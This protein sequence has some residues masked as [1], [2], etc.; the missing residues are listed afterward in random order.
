[1]GSSRVLLV[2]NSKL[3]LLIGNCIFPHDWNGGNVL[4]HSITRVGDWK[5]IR[6]YETGREEHYKPRNDPAEQ[7]DLASDV[8][9]SDKRCELAAR[10]DVWMNLVDAQMPLPQGDA[11]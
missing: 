4:P 6:S 5:L 3:D 1:M 7:H 9:R 11:K 8:S 10:L 2:T